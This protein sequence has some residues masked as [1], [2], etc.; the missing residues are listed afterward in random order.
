ML[1]SLEF[2]RPLQNET[3]DQVIVK[4][5]FGEEIVGK[6]VREELLTSGKPVVVESH[7]E[8]LKADAHWSLATGDFQR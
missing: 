3:G 7:V 2:P 6:L 8:L 1:R 5:W 4:L